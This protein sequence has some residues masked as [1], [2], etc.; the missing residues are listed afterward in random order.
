MMPSHAVAVLAAVLGLGAVL[1]CGSPRR[2]PPAGTEVAPTA[3]V[4]LRPLGSPSPATGLDAPIPAVPS[5][6]PGTAETLVALAV[7]D[8]AERTGAATSEVVVERVEP[9][10]WPDR[11]LGCPEPGV[12]YA[13]VLTPG[14]LIVARVRGQQLHYHA[15]QARV[16]VCDA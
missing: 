2:A 10:E 7:A 5:P 8:A 9:R 1:A 3:A 14:F 4:G 12:G 16:I 15:D 6:S 11:S 13:Q